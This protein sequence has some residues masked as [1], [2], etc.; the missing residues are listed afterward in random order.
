MPS[1]FLITARYLNCSPTK[2]LAGSIG[3][4][5]PLSKELP[6]RIQYNKCELRM[7][8]NCSLARSPRPHYRCVCIKPQCSQSAP[9]PELTARHCWCN[10]APWTR[11]WLL[12]QSVIRQS[13][14]C[15]MNSSERP[16]QRSELGGS[17]FPLSGETTSRENCSLPSIAAY[18]S[19]S[20]INSLVDCSILT[21]PTCLGRPHIYSLSPSAH[22]TSVLPTIKRKETSNAIL[23]TI[24]RQQYRLS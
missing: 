1:H 2:L 4:C 19:H 15:T 10:K 18:C 14:T 3:H 23:L 20:N 9:S 21:P 5:S 11:Y 12:V 6:W 17:V 7:V 22:S 16:T 8:K 13:A 24:Y